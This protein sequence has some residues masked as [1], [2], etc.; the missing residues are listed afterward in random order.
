[1]HRWSRDA[2]R[3]LGI[4]LLK[5]IVKTRPEDKAKNANLI[6][7]KK[8]IKKWASLMGPNAKNDVT[9]VRLGFRI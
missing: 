8:H 5:N 3:T 2:L 4:L 1:L 6:E 7:A 9:R